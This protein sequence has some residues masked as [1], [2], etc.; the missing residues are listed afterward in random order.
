MWMVPSSF[1]QG[2]GKE[3]RGDNDDK[4]GKRKHG[5]GSDDGPRHLQGHN[6]E[7][8]DNPEGGSDEDQDE[9]DGS[10]GGDGGG[11]SGAGNGGGSGYNGSEVY[12]SSQR[13]AGS[14]SRH[15]HSN[16]GWEAALAKEQVPRRLSASRLAIDSALG[17]AGSGD[18]RGK[19]AVFSKPTGKGGIANTP[20]S[21]FSHVKRNTSIG[22][23]QLSLQVSTTTAHHPAQ[24][25]PY[26]AG[27]YDPR[28]AGHHS[29]L[30]DTT[31]A[32]ATTAANATHRPSF[33]LA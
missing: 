11:G 20:P 5:R 3:R 31:H 10:G 7:D 17:I 4:R 15:D 23:N 32:L 8:G 26:G 2:C 22:D 19:E 29:I 18:A 21:N 30:R 14:I 16:I 12:G 27:L 1:S 6:F 25:R 33:S 9:D 24:H 28:L 13:G